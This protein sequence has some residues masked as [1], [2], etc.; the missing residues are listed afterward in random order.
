[1]FCNVC[2]NYGDVQE[3][4][5]ADEDVSEVILAFGGSKTV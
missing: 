1:V 3:E 4:E 2:V 5:Y